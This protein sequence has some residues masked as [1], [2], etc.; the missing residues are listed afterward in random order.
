MRDPPPPRRVC[1]EVAYIQMEFEH[2]CRKLPLHPVITIS[3][4]I[5]FVRMI[6]AA[7]EILHHIV[8]MIWLPAGRAGFYSRQGQDLYL[9]HHAQIDSGAGP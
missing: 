6:E 3:V 9:C 7:F 5:I 1:H 2:V 4:H 8:E